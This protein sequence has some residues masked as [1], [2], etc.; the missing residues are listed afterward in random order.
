MAL[1]ADLPAPI[2]SI[3]FIRYLDL[4]LKVTA[5]LDSTNKKSKNNQPV[6]LSEMRICMNIHEFPSVQQQ[7]FRKAEKKVFCNKI[8]NFLDFC[9]FIG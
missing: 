6:F 5:L 1:L 4:G 8:H 2:K 3:V 7:V 9:F